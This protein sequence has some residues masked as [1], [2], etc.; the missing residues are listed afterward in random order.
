MVIMAIIIIVIVLHIRSKPWDLIEIQD[1]QEVII[2][3][4]AV[5]VPLN[6]FILVRSKSVY[7]AV[8]FTGAWS[9]KNGKGKY[10]NY[11]SYY[12]D[13][14]TG[15]FKNDNAVYRI[16]ELSDPELIGI[17]RFA[18]NLGHTDIECGK[19]RLQWTGAGFIYFYGTGER[20]ADC[21]VELAPTIWTDVSQINVF[22]KWIKWYNYDEN[23]HR[24]IIPIDSLWSDSLVLR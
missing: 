23:R 18:L 7:G 15:D 19:F 22:D 9:T 21:G 12:Q 4:N 14:G 10:A 2:G 20:Q 5:F 8:K 1:R 3:Q 13:D 24:R 6:R 11:E 17:G 16:D